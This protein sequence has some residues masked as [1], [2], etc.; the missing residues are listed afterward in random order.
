M[1]RLAAVS[2]LGG[3]SFDGQIRALKLA[4]TDEDAEVRAQAA[5]ALG[6]SGDPRAVEALA[7]AC[8]DDDIWVRSAAVRSLGMLGAEAAFAAVSQTVFDPVG[9]VSIAALETLSAI[10]PDRARPVLIGA[11]AHSDAE[12]VKAA[13]QML[14]GADIDWLP[15][16]QDR[17]LSHPQADVRLSFVRHLCEVGD[18]GCRAV[19]QGRL[20]QEKDDLVR[21]ALQDCLAQLPGSEG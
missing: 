5:Q 6:Q 3:H 20:L 15:D 17:L 16:E 10:A 4:L 9:L 12:V 7:L 21:Q 2:V 18:T 8:Q 13:L 1:V 14:F 19:L 11:L